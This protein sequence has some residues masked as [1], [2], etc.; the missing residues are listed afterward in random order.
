MPCARAAVMLAAN[1][2]AGVRRLITGIFDHTISNMYGQAK[3]CW[4]DHDIAVT[5]LR[6]I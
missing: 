1:H 4:R 6:E 3:K 5:T 2:E